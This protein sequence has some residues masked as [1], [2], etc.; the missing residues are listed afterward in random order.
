MKPACKSCDH[1]FL[2]LDAKGVPEPEIACALDGEHHDR[3]HACSNF[4]R[5]IELDNSCS[6]SKG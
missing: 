6:D 1:A 3:R 2:I 5:G 4:G